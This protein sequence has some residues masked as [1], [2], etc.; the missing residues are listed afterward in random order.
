MEE[1]MTPEAATRKLFEAALSGNVNYAREAIDAGVA[2]RRI[3]ELLPWNI[4][5]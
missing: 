4:R 1:P 2:V 5:L 3:D